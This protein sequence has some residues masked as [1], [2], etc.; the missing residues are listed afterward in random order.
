MRRY[1]VARKSRD[2]RNG[3]VY[4]GRWGPFFS[5]Q[6][7]D[8]SHDSSCSGGCTTADMT[9]R[10]SFVS[11]GAK[12]PSRIYRFSLFMGI[13][14]A[15]DI[16]FCFFLCQAGYTLVSLNIF[17]QSSRHSFF[18]HSDEVLRAVGLG[19]SVRQ[20]SMPRRVRVWQAQARVILCAHRYIQLR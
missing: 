18:T 17:S 11:C 9:S 2:Q 1:T 7:N 13:N 5:S 10:Y 15:L 19:F 14:T 12:I 20:P 4:G 8:I 3:L 6:N 16:T